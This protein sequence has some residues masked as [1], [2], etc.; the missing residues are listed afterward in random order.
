[1]EKKFCHAD[2]KYKKFYLDEIEYKA[3]FAG[4]PEN[5]SEHT[6][7]KRSR[8]SKGVA[9]TISGPVQQAPITAFL[10]AHKTTPWGRTDQR[11]VQADAAFI[12]LI[13]SG[14]LPFL[15]GERPAFQQFLASLNTG[16]SKVGK[17]VKKFLFCRKKN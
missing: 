9:G 15:T 11:L 3:P 4:T 5:E 13:C 14:A 12:K 1:L 8:D 17:L 2:I 10:S 6:D 7:A 16:Y